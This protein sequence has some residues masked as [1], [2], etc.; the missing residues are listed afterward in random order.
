MAIWTPPSYV[1]SGA[2]SSAQFNEETVDNLQY[3]Y[4]LLV[5]AAGGPWTAYTPADSGITV[6]NGT[7]SA[8]YRLISPKTCMFRWALKLGSTSA[9][10]VAAVGLPF[11]AITTG[12]DRYQIVPAYY[13]DAG[14][15]NYVGVGRIASAATTATLIHTEAGGN[16]G[17]DATSPFTWTTGDAIAVEGLFELA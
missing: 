13:L 17:V 8:A 14:T 16:G 9:I 11:T 6:G 10:T 1:T 3:L 5:G 7:R 2:S 15:R 12:T 4:D